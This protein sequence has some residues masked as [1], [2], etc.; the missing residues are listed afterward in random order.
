MNEWTSILIGSVVFGAFLFWLSRL[1]DNATRVSAQERDRKEKEKSQARREE[2]Q[3]KKALTTQQNIAGRIT[4]FL[5]AA[6]KL[7]PTHLVNP[8]AKIVVHNLGCL[9]GSMTHEIFVG[10]K[11]QYHTLG[12]VQILIDKDNKVWSESPSFEAGFSTASSPSEEDV[13]VFSRKVAEF[14]RTFNV[15]SGRYMPWDD[16]NI[17]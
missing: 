8:Q 13:E 14:I 6:A 11:N 5:E 10:W 1:I 7:N 2:R 4:G 16:G 15:S 9:H 12:I 17:A 3:E